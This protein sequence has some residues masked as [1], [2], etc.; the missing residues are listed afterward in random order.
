M[1]LMGVG[2]A[3]SVMTFPLLN[4]YFILNYDWQ[5]A[6]L[7]LAAILLVTFVIPP[8]LAVRNRPEEEGLFPDWKYDPP[9]KYPIRATKYSPHITRETWTRSEALRNPTF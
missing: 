9:E 3:L 7:V 6:W 5:T 2:G 1:G 8:W 4:R